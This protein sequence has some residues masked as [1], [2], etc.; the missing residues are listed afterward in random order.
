MFF[1]PI[2][3]LLKNG[4]NN[5]IVYSYSILF[6]F[7]KY[8]F[9]I[10]CHIILYKLFFY[11]FFLITFGLLFITCLCLYECV[12]IISAVLFHCN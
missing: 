9:D 4:N 10:E 3:T 5:D 1:S 7:T 11:I 6:M 12:Y 2:N 8:L